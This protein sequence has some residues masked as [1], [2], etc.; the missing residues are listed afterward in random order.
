[1]V[2]TLSLLQDK[3][4]VIKAAKEASSTNEQVCDNILD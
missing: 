3:V 1:M 4:S 2:M